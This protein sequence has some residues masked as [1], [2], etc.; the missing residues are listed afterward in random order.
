MITYPSLAMLALWVDLDH[1][2]GIPFHGWIPAMVGPMVIGVVLVLYWPRSEQVSTM[3]IA[4]CVLG[5]LGGF[6]ILTDLVFGGA[7][8]LL[9]P[10]ATTTFTS[11]DFPGIW[12]SALLNLTPAEM[13]AVIGLASLMPMRR[14]LELLV[15]EVEVAKIPSGTREWT[16]GL[17]SGG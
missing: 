3:A 14:L 2:T 6:H 9:A 12:V 11:S 17:P 5:F 1:L 7:K 16:S 8:A 15:V 4:F 13:I 10:F